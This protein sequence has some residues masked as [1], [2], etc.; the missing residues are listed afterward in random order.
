MLAMTRPAPAAEHPSPL[1]PAQA[2]AFARLALKGVSKEYPNKPEHVLA[3]PEDAKGPKALHPAFYGCY[4][5]HSSVHGHWMLA[6]LLRLFPELPEAKD[7]RGVLEAHLTPE[8]LKVEAEYFDRKE[9]RSFE[10]PYGWAWLL[11]LTEELNG[12]DDPDAKRWRA[13][14]KPLA[15]VIAARYLDF[16]PK[17][18]YPIRTGVHPNTAFGLAFAHDYA[19]AMGD[20]KLKV[21]VEERA[22]AYF[23]HDANVPA[24]WEPGGA[25]FFSPSLMEADLMR[26]VLPA[27]EFRPWFAGFLPGASKG[28]P[29]ALFEPATVTDR[30]DPQLVHLDGLNLSRAWG[31]KRIASTFPPDDPMRSALESSAARHAE[32]GLAHVASGDYAGEH[33]LASFAV[34][35]LSYA[36]D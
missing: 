26:R 35:M 10:R 1:T 24:G 18:T 33:W 22:R 4:D 28:E 23:G 16:F 29:R 9:S 34:Y 25:D 14:L 19:R 30:L 7:I 3:G 5:W 27:E 12:W 13:N 6:R 8:A 20:S 36:N 21:L 32:A 15:D 17:Q 31:M 2:S 11:K